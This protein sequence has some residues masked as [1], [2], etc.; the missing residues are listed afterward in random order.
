MPYL[1]DN[2]CTLLFHKQKAKSCQISNIKYILV[3]VVKK[4]QSNQNLEIKGSFTLKN[5]FSLFF[6]CF[7]CLYSDRNAESLK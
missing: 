7:E 4:T 6:M 5:H 3:T 2:A 1:H